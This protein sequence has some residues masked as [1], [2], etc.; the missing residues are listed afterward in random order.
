MSDLV[1]Y[2]SD[3]SSAKMNTSLVLEKILNNT[4]NNIAAIFSGNRHKRIFH[5][6]INGIK[7]SITDN[8]MYS[9]DFS[10]DNPLYTISVKEEDTYTQLN[11]D[12]RVF[13]VN[14]KRRSTN[15]D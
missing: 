4:T 2:S 1:G 3:Y 7:F 10:I 8:N 12:N 15:N 6:Y 14:I 9:L 11:K 5:G 13:I